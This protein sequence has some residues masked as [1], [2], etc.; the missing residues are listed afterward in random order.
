MCARACSV[1]KKVV[2]LKDVR[3]AWSGLRPLVKAEGDDGSS[4]TAQISRQVRVGEWWHAPTHP[5]TP[6][7]CQHRV[8]VSDSNLVSICGGKWTTYRKCVTSC[9]GA[10]P[11][12]ALILTWPRDRRMAEDTIDKVLEVT[13]VHTSRKCATPSLQV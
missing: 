7:A 3:A 9:A 6:S 2:Q 4:G 8:I 1:L 13:P 10:R 12:V 5:L 11:F